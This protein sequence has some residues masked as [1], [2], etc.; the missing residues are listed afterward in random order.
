MPT[1]SASGLGA[2]CVRSRAAVR[3]VVGIRVY[4]VVLGDRLPCV[5]NCRDDAQKI[6]FGKH[7]PVRDGIGL[8]DDASIGVIQ[9]G[10][11]VQ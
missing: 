3:A 4:C 1:E 6:D 9:Y 5:W 2:G 11:A 10:I 8:I 7:K